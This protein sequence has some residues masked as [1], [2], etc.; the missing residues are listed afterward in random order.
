[1]DKK[2]LFDS[3]R[4]SVIGRG[5]R[6]GIEPKS[7]YVCVL[8]FTKDSRGLPLALGCMVEY[9]QI[10]C[11]WTDTAITGKA[12]GADPDIL[13]SA[14]R[15]M[16]DRSGLDIQEADRWYFLGFMT[17]H[18]MINQEFACFAVDVTG[19]D[20]P[21]A[22][23]KDEDAEPDE[24]DPRFEMRGVNQAL[25]TDDCFIPTMFM[26][27]FRYIF[28]FNTPEDAGEETES[29]SKSGDEIMEI[30]GVIGV[31]E[32][33]GEWTVSVETGSDKTSIKSKVQSILGDDVSIDVVEKQ[34]Q[35]KKSE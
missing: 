35:N 22:E 12:E 31:S 23:E 4:F 16:L 15:K 7:Q 29:D 27:V 14:Q 32:E 30:E 18:K 17:T 9:N 13:S 10:R 25:D 5:D 28:G 26:K 24:Y 3:D 21:E 6:V 33:N 2:I 1:M 8:P 20:L 34:K 19:V 11:K